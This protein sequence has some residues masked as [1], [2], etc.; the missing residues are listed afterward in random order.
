MIVYPEYWRKDYGNLHPDKPINPHVPNIVKELTQVIEKIDISH[1]AYSG[2]IDSTIM[3]C[4]MSRVFGNVSTYTISSRESHPDTIHARSGSSFYKSNH[5]EFIVEPMDD[6]NL[7]DDAVRQ[8]FRKVSPI[9]DSIICCDGVDEFMCGYYAHMKS[10]DL[11]TYNKYLSQLTPEH[12]L[13]LNNNSR[14]VKVYLPYL[15]EGIVSTFNSIP[16]SKKIDMETRKKVVVELAIYLELPIG[17]ILRNKYGFCDAFLKEDKKD[18]GW[19]LDD[20]K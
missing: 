5:H 19:F 12:L 16:L 15:D 4:L 3:L 7:G 14:N 1:L 6:F 8:L 13:P 20:D 18:K 11:Y 2:G 9:T 10:P 17:I